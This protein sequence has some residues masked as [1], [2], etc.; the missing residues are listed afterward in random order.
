[1]HMSTT[2]REVEARNLQPGD[3]I[4]HRYYDATGTYRETDVPVRAARVFT[5]KVRI[6]W[7]GSWGTDSVPATKIFGV[8]ETS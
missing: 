7:G 6:T 8:K 5:R 4:L 3:A 2:Y 1:M